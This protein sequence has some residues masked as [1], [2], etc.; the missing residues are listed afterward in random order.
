[1]KTIFL[2]MS[3]AICL[4][5]ACSLSSTHAIQQ[6]TPEDGK[7]YNDGYSRTSTKNSTTSAKEVTSL[8]NLTLDYYLRRVSG[9]SV[10]GDGP[11]ATVIIR[12]VNSI[13]AGITPLF[14]LNGSPIE[15]GYT[16]VYNMVNPNEIKSVSVLKDP[17]DTGIYGSRGANGVIV[18]SLK[19]NN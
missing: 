5:L 19:K 6:S 10:L 8:D 17:S 11:G 14:I 1:M 15:G 18:I 13:H 2:S 3:L 9:V 16:A 4:S 7:G 12:G